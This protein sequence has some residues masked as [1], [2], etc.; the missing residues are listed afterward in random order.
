VKVTLY[1]NLPGGER[2]EV[3]FIDMPPAN[4]QDDMP[5]SIACEEVRSDSYRI[6]IANLH[7]MT[8][9]YINFTLQ[10]VSR[11]GVGGCM[12]VKTDREGALSRQD[13]VPG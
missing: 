6:E 12:D 13:S 8:L 1:A 10:P 5:V 4:W 3:A 9:R 11:M 7:E 2:R